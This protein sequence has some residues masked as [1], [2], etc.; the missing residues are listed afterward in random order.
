VGA[1]AGELNAL[2]QTRESDSRVVTDGC[3]KVAAALDVV[4]GAD[5]ASRFLVSVTRKRPGAWWR[6]E[7]TLRFATINGLPGVIV[8]GPEGPVQ[9]TA[10]EIEGEGVRALDVVRNPD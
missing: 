4:E 8:D 9:T 10:F 6:E 7:F 2:T 1:H 3:G 5:R